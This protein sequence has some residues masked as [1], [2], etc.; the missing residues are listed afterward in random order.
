M[1]MALEM[2]TTFLASG[3]T[4]VDKMLTIYRRDGAYFVAFHEFVKSIMLGDRKY[5]KE[6]AS[7]VMN[8]FDC[9]ADRNS[10]HFTGLRILRF[11]LSR[12]GETSREGQGYY[13]IARLVSALED[14]FDN[15]EDVIRALNKMVDRQ[16]LEVNTRSTESIDGASHARVTSRGLVLLSTPRRA[17]RVFGPSAPGHTTQ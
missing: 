13:E 5:Y 9:S 1:R 17:L 7:P 16:L 12:R 3:A 4:D 14:V 8:L 10:S 15:R 6:S 11:L 2:F